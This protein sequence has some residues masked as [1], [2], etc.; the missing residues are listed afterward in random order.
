MNQALNANPYAAVIATPTV[1]SST[2]D[3]AMPASVSTVTGGSVIAA[4]AQRTAAHSNLVL[5]QSGRIVTGGSKRSTKRTMFKRSTKRTMS[6]RKRSTKRTMFKR[7]TKR[8]MFKRSKRGGVPT[9]GPSPGPSVIPVPQ[10]AVAHNAGAN[11][12]SLASNRVFTNAAAQ[13]AFDNPNAP[14][15]NTVVP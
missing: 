4:G 1:H 12:N 11:A 2:G 6:K 7:S 5:T 15:S 9:P 14:A 8:S 10:F 3:A 13:R